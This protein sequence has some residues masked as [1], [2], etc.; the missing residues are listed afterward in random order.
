MKPPLFFLIGLPEAATDMTKQAAREVF[1]D[2]EFVS[3]PT[4]QAALQHEGRHSRQLMVLGDRDEAEIA[5]AAQA[6]DADETPRWATVVLG[7][8]PSELIESIALKECTPPMLAHLFRSAVLQHEL[9]RENLQLRGDLKTLARRLGHDLRSPLNCLHL[10]CELMDE[11]LN[12]DPASVKSQIGV[13][14][15][16]LAEITQ[17]VE[18]F[19]EVLR[20]SA[21]PLPC[22]EV[23]MDTVVTGV[24]AEL[25][26]TIRQSGVEVKYPEQWPTVLGVARWL[27]I[28]WWNLLMNALKH[29]RPPSPIEM[30]W[31]QEDGVVRCWVANHG[32]APSDEM[33]SNLFPRFDRLHAHN[34]QGLGLSLVQRLVSLQKGTCGYQR[35]E[36]DCSVFYFTL[37]SA[38]ATAPS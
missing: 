17:L 6:T 36:D 23:P 5:L 7:R 26:G 34:G 16:S 35:R 28:V 33:A 24:L 1:P 10:N 12:E 29:N 30:G 9:V 2:A 27:E 18:R 21:D 4:V 3:L 25:E 20:A 15:R 22:R 37:P 38:S 32:A 14:R 11:L 19:C 8:S 13:T 31:N